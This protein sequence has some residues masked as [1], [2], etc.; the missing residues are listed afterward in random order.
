[1]FIHKRHSFSVINIRDTCKDKELE[2]CAVK[3]KISTIILCIF[4]IYLSPSR[5]V[6]FF[7]K[8]LENILKK[9]INLKIN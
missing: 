8:H 2:A 1:M 7:L 9:Y 4:T 6:R 3:L 5:N